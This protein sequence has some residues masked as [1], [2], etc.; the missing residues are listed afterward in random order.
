M[1][2]AKTLYAANKIA[3]EHYLQAY[4]AAFDIPWT[5]LRICVPY[6]N[7]FG[8][9]YSFGT[10]GN[11]I[12]QAR[13]SG[14]ISIFGS[15]SGKRTFTHVDDICRFTLLAARH[16]E[17][18]NRTFNI[19]GEQLTIIEAAVLVSKLMEVVIENLEWPDLDQRIETGST[20]LDGSSL[21]SILQTSPQY[22]FAEWLKSTDLRRHTA[23]TIS[24][25]SS[26]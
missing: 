3:C 18:I 10:I 26:P 17:T 16:T 25:H 9:Q 13:N 8:D 1:Q 15:G 4:S 5:V 23:S 22:K 14:R 24:L 21:L 20:A 19:P 12:R 7:L 11:F 2:A 6:G